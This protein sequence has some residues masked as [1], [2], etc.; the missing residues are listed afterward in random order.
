MSGKIQYHEKLDD[1]FKLQYHKI[2]NNREILRKISKIWQEQGEK[3]EHS[4]CIR[5]RGDRRTGTGDF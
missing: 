5:D 4:D 3:N 2:K 1:K